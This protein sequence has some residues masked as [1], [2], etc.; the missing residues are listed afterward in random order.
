MVSHEIPV[1][2]IDERDDKLGYVV[3]YLELPARDVGRDLRFFEYLA[4]VVD[5]ARLN[6]CAADVDTD[7]IHAH[8][9]TLF[10]DY[11]AY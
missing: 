3:Y 5:D 6:A 9:S 10:D 11:S 8:S 1:V 2:G 7:T 4:L